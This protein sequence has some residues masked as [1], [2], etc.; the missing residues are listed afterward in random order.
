MVLADYQI[1]DRCHPDRLGSEFTGKFE[2]GDP[3]HPIFKTLKGK[4]M[5]SPFRDEQVEPASYDVR[6][7]YRFRVFERDTTTHIDLANPTDITK[8]VLISEGGAFTLHPGEF[9][10]AETYERVCIPHDLVARIEGKSSIGRLG[11]LVHVTAGYIDPGFEGKITLE[12]YGLHPL[13]LLL[14]PEMLVAQLSFHRL[15]SPPKKPYQGRYQGASGVE[16]SKYSGFA[17]EYNPG[18]LQFTDNQPKKGN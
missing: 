2:D 13:P 11:L 5:I 14:R 16:A 7:G 15:L 3:N 12:M 17:E 18:A 10:L 9:V 4:P 1:A 6:L 8:E